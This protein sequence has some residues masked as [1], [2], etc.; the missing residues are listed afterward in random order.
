MTGSSRVVMRLAGLAS[1]VSA[2]VAALA[3][4]LLIAMF[5]AFGSGATSA[6]QT[7]GAIND[8]LTLVAYAL[9]APGV[10]AT[11]AI[12]RSRRPGLTM[13]CGLLA[14]GAIGAITVL[15]WQLVVGGLTFEQQIGPVSVAF[16][17]LGGWFVLSGYLGAGLLPYGVGTGL[18]AALYIG[19]P[20]LAL[21][22]G[23]VLWGS[24]P[25]DRAL[26]AVG[27]SR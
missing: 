17:L 11:M 19:Y 10:V 27:P 2:T 3:V 24:G 26:R 6:G 9:A 4:A 25:V 22:L 12:L 14:L 13:A 5:V 1:L 8:R 7:L 16:V 21:R 23:K 18:L 15:Q 20:I